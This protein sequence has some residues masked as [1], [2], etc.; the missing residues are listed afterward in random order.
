MTTWTPEA[1]KAEMNYRL[2]VARRHDVVRQL[3]QARGRRHWWQ[4]RVP[5]QRQHTL[6]G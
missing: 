2:E 4:R 1:V 6:A 5:T 3:R